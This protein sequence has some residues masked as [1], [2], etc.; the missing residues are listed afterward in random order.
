M[1]VVNPEGAAGAAP[2]FTGKGR[3]KGD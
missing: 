2:A 1:P 3:V